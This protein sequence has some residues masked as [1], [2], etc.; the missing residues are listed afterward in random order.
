MLTAETLRGAWVTVLLD[1]DA[2]GRPRLAAIDEQIEAY[3]EAGV[4]GVY[5]NGTATEFHCQ[6]GASCGAVFERTARAAREA[7]LPVQL[8][9]SHPLPAEALTRVRLAVRHAPDA[10]QVTLPDWTPITEDEAIRF[11]DGCAAAAGGF[12][13]VLYNP[14]H[15]RTV[16]S[17]EGLARVAE[18]VPALIGLKCGGG[19]AGWYRAMRTVL[20][21]L[22]VFVPGHRYASGVAAGA[23]GAY[24]NIACLNPRA[25][26]RWARLGHEAPARALEIESR[27]GAFMDEAIA[28]LLAAGTPGYACDKAMAA[29]GGWTPITPRLLWPHTGVSDAAIERIRDA[30]R[31]HVPEFADAMPARG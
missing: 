12:P 24:S 3:R 8:G 14:P 9:A 21:R 27:I 10:I 31:R 13:L 4:S 28:P 7:G 1:V 16:L 23:R 29:A 20:E 11:L 18:R 17:P 25:A 5:C 26:M 2:S 30:A 6:D 22:A 15:A 19:D